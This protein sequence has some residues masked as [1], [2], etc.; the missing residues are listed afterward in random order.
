MKNLSL[1]ILF[2]MTFSF[3]AFAQ[4][5]SAMSEMNPM[6]IKPT[7]IDKTEEIPT[8]GY[9]KRGAPLSGSAMVKID[10]ITKTPDQF[11]DKTV[12]I[13]G[14]IVRSCKME[15]CWLE[16]AES[17]KSESIRVELKSHAFFVP[18]NSAGAKAKVEGA[19]TVKTLS[20]AQVKH[21][22]ED[23]GAKFDKINDDGSVTQIVF[24]ATGV[25]LTR[26]K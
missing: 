13:E 17:E 9:L 21:M 11:K 3:A 24:E 12:T 18:L 1:A 7:E 2:I 4:E 22:I 15:G 6:G 25:E 26:K 16:I 10:S 8:S 19:L 5:K 20:A 23:D 14:V